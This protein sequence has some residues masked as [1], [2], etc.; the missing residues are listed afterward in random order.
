MAHGERLPGGGVITFS[1]DCC[2]AVV[3]VSGSSPT[4]QRCTQCGRP[5]T[6]FTY[7]VTE[8]DGS[9]SCCG[10]TATVEGRTT[11]YYACSSC[12]QPCDVT[13]SSLQLFLINSCRSKGQA[14]SRRQPVAQQDTKTAY[15]VTLQEPYGEHETDRAQ[16][17]AAM[18][19]KAAVKNKTGALVDVVPDKTGPGGGVLVRVHNPVRDRKDGQR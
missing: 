18:L 10:A 3:Q 11:R 6:G 4:G 14:A 17:V 16:R 1:S 15:E 8:R 7:E 13:V 9:S 12:G 2:L 19:R 5:C